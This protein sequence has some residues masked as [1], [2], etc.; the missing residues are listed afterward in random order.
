MGSGLEVRKKTVTVF[1][2]KIK[3]K[4]LRLNCFCLIKSKKR[5]KGEEKRENR[6]NSRD[7][8]RKGNQK[9]LLNGFTH[10]APGFPQ[11]FSP[12]RSQLELESLSSRHESITIELTARDR[13]VGGITRGE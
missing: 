2:I 7:L 11:P 10:A 3:I 13:E 12:P 5:R 9:A 4:N 8:A 1:F 6:V